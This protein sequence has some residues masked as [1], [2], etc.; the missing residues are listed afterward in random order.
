M[1][2]VRV[3]GERLVV[4]IHGLD[5]L[6]SLRSRLVVPLA[7]VKGARIDPYL[8]IEEPWVGAGVTDATLGWTVAAGPM[9][10]HGEREFWAVHH[11]HKAIAIDLKGESFSRLVLEVQNPLAT[12]EAVNSAV[13]A[14]REGDDAPRPASRAA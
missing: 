7:H 13:R 8:E 5:V 2:E 4:E 11:P 14:L 10:L 1:V 12:I 6:W 3:R 9:L